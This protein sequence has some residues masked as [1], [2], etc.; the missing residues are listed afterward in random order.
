[1][2]AKTYS[3]ATQGSDKLSKNFRV[4]EF[5]CNDGSDK[6]LIADE[7]VLLLQAIRTHFK[8]AVVMN[9][10]YRNL[11]YNRSIGSSDSSYHVK[12]MAADFNVAGFSPSAV[13]KEIES[14][15]VK[16]VCPDQIGLGSYPGFTHIDS[17]GFKGR[18]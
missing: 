11:R 9:S 16:G 18:W 8:R 7:L 4:D 6:I 14:G 2:K 1:M 10:A 12:G 13:R 3:K 17:R 5:A 15:N